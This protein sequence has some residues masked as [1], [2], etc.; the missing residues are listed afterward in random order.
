MI[1]RS[2]SSVIAA[3]CMAV[4]AAGA[5]CNTPELSSYSCAPLVPGRFTFG[6]TYDGE[7]TFDGGCPSMHVLNGQTVTLVFDD[8]GGVTLALATQTLSCWA[9]SDT[10]FGLVV[11][12]PLPPTDQ[13][14]ISLDAS[15]AD[16]GVWANVTY[17]V[18]VAETADAVTSVCQEAYVAQ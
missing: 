17:L 13:V 6:L 16:A 12:C 14:E 3:V 5:A 11:H 15:C 1:G 7:Y 10:L 18:D 9:T 4:A 2:R 8:V